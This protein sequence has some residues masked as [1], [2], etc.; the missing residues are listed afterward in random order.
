MVKSKQKETDF[1][2]SLAKQLAD[3]YKDIR[4]RGIV[5][6][7]KFILTKINKG[8]TIFFNIFWCV[9]IIVHRDRLELGGGLDLI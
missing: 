8:I 6:F 2:G 3:N 4:D 7:R 1:Y 5:R 9:F